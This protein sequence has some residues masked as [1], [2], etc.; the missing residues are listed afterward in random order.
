[1]RIPLVLSVALIAGS[2]LAAS[3]VRS[4][5]SAVTL[6]LIAGQG[7]ANGGLNFN[8]GYKGSKTFTVPLGSKVTVKFQDM[9]MMP[10]SF[11]I[12]RGNAVPTDA[13]VSDA[14]F[15]RAYAPSKVEAG[16]KP[17]TTSQ[18]VFSAN[19]AGSYYIVCGVPGHAM[20]G[21]YIRL[22]ISK[23]ARAASFN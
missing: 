19:K 12:R 22:V 1:M 23:T 20:A 5:G 7:G 10:H 3:P 21:Q 2:S 14:A 18:V 13:D 9:G 8:G 16:I 15:P 4:S 11:V 6:D 17:G